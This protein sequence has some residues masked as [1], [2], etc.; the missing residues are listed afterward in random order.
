MF[1]TKE[2]FAQSIKTKFPDYAE[3]DDLELAD[4]MLIKFPQYKD[5]VKS[6]QK[7]GW[8][9]IIESAKGVI[10]GVAK[11]AMKGLMTGVERGQE[12]EAMIDAKPADTL[13]GKI[14]QAGVSYLSNKL[15]DAEKTAGL[16]SGA[17]TGGL[18]PVVEPIATRVKESPKVQEAVEFTKETGQAVFNTLP[19]E[20]QEAL[21]TG[22]ALPREVYQTLTPYQQSFI[23][24]L[25]GTAGSGINILSTVPLGGAG[26]KVLKEGVEGVV[27]AAK[28]TPQIAKEAKEIAGD[29][30]TD[31]SDT[32]SRAREARVIKNRVK[33]LAAIQENNAPLRRVFNKIEN[34][35]M[36]IKEELAKT[37]L[38]KGT[39]DTDGTIKTQEAIA[40]LNQAIEPA[41]DVVYKNLL[42]ETKTIPLDV[43]RKRMEDDVMKSGVKGGA[44]KRALNTVD[45]EIEGYAIEAIDVD[46]TPSLPL[47]V[48]HEAKVDKYGNINYMNPESKKIDKRIAKSLKE[49]VEEEATIIDVKEVNGELK[50]FYAMQNA[51]EALDGK[52]VKGG[53]L[54]KYTAQVIGATIGS[55]FGALG[56]LAGAELGNII[57]GLQMGRTFAG[58]AGKALERGKILDEAIELGQSSKRGNLNT[59]Q[60]TTIMPVKNPIDDIKD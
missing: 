28:K 48:I 11:G 27:D 44:L 32:I 14:K 26:G 20:A 5:K 56:A 3:V 50:K 45:D 2:E 1:Q 34:D 7:Y 55:Q 58:K 6:A 4:K 9:D 25:V 37:D 30:T 8:S 15:A 54:G 36:D 21:K 18:A 47:A 13:G 24:S 46:G 31:V 12:R 38:L 29:I 53:R 39:V 17:I 22:Y 49:I 23:S 16:V 57:K 51:L 33:E 60:S 52:K 19:D 35:G 10:P 40:K 59:S 43:L 42:N 41:E